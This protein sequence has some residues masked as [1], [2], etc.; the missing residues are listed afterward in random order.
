[1]SI[2]CALAG[3]RAGDEGTYNSG[4]RF[5]SCRRC[6]RDMIRCGDDWEPIPAGHRVVWKAGRHSHSVEPDYA[7][8]LPAVH[9][10]ANLPA[11]RTG[12]LSWSRQL[13]RVAA[14]R[15]LFGTSACAV[16]DEPEVETYPGLLV[17][18]A[19]V[20]AGLQLVFG[21]GGR[22]REC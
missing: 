1:M 10:D 17:L 19:L 14:R 7:S 22:R 18:A 15:R 16:A 4:Y 3:H 13:S 9:R 5:S 11:V 21:I 2:L 6:G 8:V 20:G 12:F